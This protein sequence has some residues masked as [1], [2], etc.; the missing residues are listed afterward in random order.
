MELGFTIVL[1]CRGAEYRIA[2]TNRATGRPAKLVVDGKAIEGTLVPY[3]PAG[4]VVAIAC[5][6]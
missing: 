1:K 5:E 4:K 2:V 3:A 6:V